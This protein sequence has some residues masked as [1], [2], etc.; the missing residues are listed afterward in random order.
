MDHAR[1]PCGVEKK[2]LESALALAAKGTHSRHARLSA[3]QSAGLINR[4]CQGV[5]IAPWEVEQLDEEWL[6]IFYGLADVNRWK[7]SAEQFD[8]RLK[9][10]RSQ[11]PTYRK[12]MH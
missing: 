9:K 11:H 7:R 1:R 4:I 5:V 3:V 10:V 6:D 12:Y 8:E 2:R